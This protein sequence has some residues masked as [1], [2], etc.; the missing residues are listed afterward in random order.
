[1]NNGLLSSTG[2][3][4]GLPKGPNCIMTPQPALKG[5]KWLWPLKA[6]VPLSHP[7]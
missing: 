4:E 5:Q 6:L 2:F 3:F 7:N 1:M